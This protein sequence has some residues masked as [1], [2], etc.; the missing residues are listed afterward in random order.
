M[1]QPFLWQKVHNFMSDIGHVNV[2]LCTKIHVAQTFF[3]I[4]TIFGINF[5][6]FLHSP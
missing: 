5:R 6:G 3:E 2:E 4:F 1:C